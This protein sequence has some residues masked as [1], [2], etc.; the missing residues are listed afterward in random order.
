[1]AEDSPYKVLIFLKRRP[2][3][4]VEEFRDYY[5]NHHRPLVEKYSAGL[6][7]YVRRYLEPLP[8][9]D[10]KEMSEPEFDVVTELWC[11]NREAFDDLLNMVK[12]GTLLP[13]VLE[14]EERIFD[15]PRTRQVYLTECEG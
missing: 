11:A 14:D 10:T 4:S 3:M 8:H 2:G 6:S 15:H 7:R 13:E 1:M 5:E 12:F 9:L